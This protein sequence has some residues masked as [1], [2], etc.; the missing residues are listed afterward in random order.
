MDKLEK[1]V[2]ELDGT[3]SALGAAQ[4]GK[5]AGNLTEEI[6]VCVC[7]YRIIRASERKL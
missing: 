7:V 4:V 5:V 2:C 1:E 6:Q 3:C